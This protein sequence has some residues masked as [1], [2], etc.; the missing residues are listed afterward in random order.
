MRI[1]IDLIQGSW[2][3]QILIKFYI[4]SLLKK[5]ENNNTWLK[6]FAY[7]IILAVETKEIENKVSKIL[8]LWKSFEIKLNQNKLGVMKL[9]YR[10]KKV[11]RTK[12]TV[13]ISKVSKYKY[14]GITANQSLKS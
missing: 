1:S 9:L 3:S 4:N 13:N 11:K 8:E 12:N 14:L 10:S 7:N 2:L 5:L 6:T